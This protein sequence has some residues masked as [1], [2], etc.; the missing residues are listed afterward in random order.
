MG[1]A[2]V[3]RTFRCAQYKTELDKIKEQALEKMDIAKRRDGLDFVQIDL[4]SLKPKL[5]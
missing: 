1:A 3:L 5:D 4:A 2:L